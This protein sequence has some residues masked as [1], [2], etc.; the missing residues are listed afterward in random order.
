MRIF[1]TIV[2]VIGICISSSYGVFAQSTSNDTKEIEQDLLLSKEFLHKNIDSSL[3]YIDKAL[4]LSKSISNDTLLAK[5]HLQKSSILI[6]KKEF[7]K[8]DSL[9]QN[10][11]EKVL[12]KHIEGQTWHNL[13]T[14]Q[15][16]KQDFEKALNLYLKAVEILENAG[17]RKLLVNSYTNIGSINAS[18]KYY[19]KAVNYLEKALPLSDFNESIRLQI[20]VNLSSIY[21]NQKL[22]KKYLK[23]ASKAEQLAKKH[24]SK[25]VLSVIY[26]NLSNY[27]AEEGAEYNKAILYGKKAIKFKKELNSLYTIGLTYNNLG[28]SYLKKEEYRN[29]IIYLDSALPGAKGLLKSYIYNNLKDSHIGLKDYKKAMHYA[30]LKDILKDSITNAQQKEK[31]A[32][33]TEKFESEKKQQQIDILDTKNELQALTISQQKYLLMVLFAFGLLFIILGYFGFKNYKTKQQLDTVLLQQKVRKMQLNPHFLFNALQSIQ[34]FIYQNDKEKSSSYLA[35]Y[36][37]LIRMILEKS[38]DDFI[39]IEDDKLALEAYLNLQQLTYNDSFSYTIDVEETVDEDFDRL[40]S[41]ITQPFVENAVLHGI[42]NIN[43]GCIRVKY[44]KKNNT[45]FVSITDNGK[46][47]GDEKENSKKL[48]KSMSMGIIKE[49]LKNLNKTSKNFN[50]NIAISSST[51]GTEVLLS[52]TAA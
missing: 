45:L 50:G 49:Q 31:V 33:L 6:F 18:L 9:L 52:F 13:G 8:A 21:Y 40:P 36:S 16:Y 42:K 24:D 41:L 43:E 38:N 44:F 4:L 32:E 28:Y 11:L 37:K 20:L 3:F 29:A 5:S 51:T 23:S 34:N 22:F 25:R 26:S 17:N 15:Y 46:G 7:S 30:D 14:I 27:Y 48:H 2:I 39:S 10:N 47:F 1:Y 19:D 12:P 35:S